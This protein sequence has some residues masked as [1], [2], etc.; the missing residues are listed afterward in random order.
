[1]AKLTKD[2][3]SL[4][5]EFEYDINEMGG[6]I[7]YDNWNGMSAMI[8]PNDNMRGFVRVYLTY[9]SHNEK[10]RKKRARLALMEKVVNEQFVLA[11]LGDNTY[12]Q[13][14]EYM[15]GLR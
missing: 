10:F 14:A 6:Q 2:Q 15:F 1:M 12:L 5:V 13:I 9:C 4:A 7:F 3:K 8:M 11:P